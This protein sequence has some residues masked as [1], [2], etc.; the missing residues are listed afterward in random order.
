MKTLG[1]RLKELRVERKISLGK[2]EGAVNISAST[3]RD[4][5]NDNKNPTVEKLT[6][7]AEYYGVSLDYL[8]GLTEAKTVDMT[9]QAICKATGL[10]DNNVTLL[11]RMK[12]AIEE[13]IY[14]S[15]SGDVVTSDELADYVDKYTQINFI[16]DLLTDAEAL[17]IIS[18]MV[19][20]LLHKG[21]EGLSGADISR[22]EGGRYWACQNAL[23]EF[24]KKIVEKGA[25]D[26]NAT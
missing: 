8:A 9:I 20:E 22:V 17:Y 3:I 14:I 6:R 23:T 4:Y 1:E 26:P 5:E 10:H 11:G 19:N 2:L 24:I 21:S 16:N 18:H 13:D 25:G 12:E 15:L 7:L